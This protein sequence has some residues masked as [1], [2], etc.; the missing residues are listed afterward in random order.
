[1]P[2]SC[3]AQWLMCENSVHTS[4]G[5]QGT[6]LGEWWEAGWPRASSQAFNCDDSASASPPGRPAGLR[7]LA[8]R[9]PWE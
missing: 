5:V 9:W 2:R 4:A 7:E 3:C 8:S 1:M 6:A